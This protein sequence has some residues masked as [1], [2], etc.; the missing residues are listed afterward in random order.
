MEVIYF[1]KGIYLDECKSFQ[2]NVENFR[3][4][5]EVWSE[6]TDS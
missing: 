3:G 4:L 5:M 6:E 2:R 1:S